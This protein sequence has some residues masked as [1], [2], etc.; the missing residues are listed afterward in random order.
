ME[1]KETTFVCGLPCTQ[2][3]PLGRAKEGC[4]MQHYSVQLLAPL[5]GIMG[6]P[7][8]GEAGFLEK[9]SLKYIVK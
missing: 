8:V 5:N 2:I 3:F 9:T 7:Y 6:I 4:S 1:R